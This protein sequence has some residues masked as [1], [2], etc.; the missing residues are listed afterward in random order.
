MAHEVTRNAD[1]TVEIAATVAAETVSSERNGIVS[2]YRRRAQIPGF[3]PGRAPA[4]AVSTRFAEEIEGDLKERLVERAWSEFVADHDDMVPLSPPRVTEAEID[5]AGVFSFKAVL[6]VRP[7]FD[8][9]ALEDVTLP[10]HTVD[11]SEGEIE[12]ELENLREEQAVWEPLDDDGVIEDGHL[13]EADLTGAMEGSDEEPYEE[14]DASFVVGQGSVPPEINEALQGASVGDERI[15]EKRFPDDDDNTD[16]AGKTVSY[17]ITVKGIKRKMLPDL[18]DDLAVGL[19]LE[20]LDEV[21]ERIGAV[22]RNRKLGERRNAWR[23]AALD[24][25]ETGLSTDDLPPS[26]VHDA[27]HEDMNRLAYSLAMQGQ[28]DQEIDWN[29]IRVRMEPESRK[30]VLDTLV[31][32]QLAREWDVQVPEAEVEAFIAGEAQQLGLP[33]SEHRANLAKEGRIDQIRHA[34]RMAGTVSEM[35]RRAGGEEDE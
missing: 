16:R 1:H 28:A 35:I 18:D 14:K 25:L 34:A 10:E 23:R 21:R 15:A 32:E 5:T 3:R 9:P 30:R 29:Q 13:V 2:E 12:A 6:E 22:L 24:H 4:A 11:P 19:G 17:T 20:S 31:L 26:L 33:P 27:I 8:L 7:E